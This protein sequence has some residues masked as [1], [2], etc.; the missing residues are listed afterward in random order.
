MIARV[1]SLFVAVILLVPLTVT[2]GANVASASGSSAPTVTTVIGLAQTCEST[3]ETCMPMSTAQSFIS[4]SP[5]TVV[6]TLD[7]VHCSNVA[8][9]LFVDGAASVTTPF[10]DPGKNTE[11]AVV[12]WP[13][14]G[15][16]HVLGYEGFGEVGG[17][18]EGNLITW[19]GSL[20]VTYVPVKSA[21]LSVSVKLARSTIAQGSQVEATATVGASGGSVS[22]ITLGDGLTSSDDTIASVAP[23]SPGGF[24]LDDGSSKKFTFTVNA[25]AVGSVQ[26]TLNASGT[27]SS[28][29]N[30]QASG[31]ATLNVKQ[32]GIVVNTT[33]DD[34]IDDK[35]LSPDSGAPFCAI[36]ASAAKP[37]CSLRAA[38]QLV[39]KLGGHQTITFDIPGSGVPKIAVPSFGNLPKITASATI[40]GTTQSGGW[41]ELSS[42]EPLNAH[43]IAFDGSDSGLVLDGQ[44][45]SVRG[46]V[47]NGF[48]WGLWVESS[49]DDVVGDRIGT[50][51]SGEVAA[52]NAIGVFI[53]GPGAII[54]GTSGTSATSCTGDCD[55]I[56]GNA[57]E[58][59]WVD[60]GGGDLVEG[61]TIGADLTGQHL[62]TYRGHTSTGIKI[63]AAHVTIGGPITAPGQAPGNVIGSSVAGLDF[64]GTNLDRAPADLQS[65]VVAGNLIGV[66]RSGKEGLVSGDAGTGEVSSSSVKGCPCGILYVPTSSATG[67]VIGGSAAN[68]E[69]VISGWQTGVYLDDSSTTSQDSTVIDHD[70]I[71]TDSSGTAAIPNGIG[72]AGHDTSTPE[73]DFFKITG[74][75][76]LDS[77]VSGNEYGLDQ[78]STVQGD[79]VGTIANGTAAL[80]NDVGVLY[81]LNI[82]GPRPVG[83]TSCAFPCNLISGNSGQG[84]VGAQTVQGNFIGTNLDGTAAVP[85]GSGFTTVDPTSDEFE[86][87]AVAFAA[88]IGGPSGALNGVCDQ[89]C[90]LISGNDASG[91]VSVTEATIP[92]PA[93][94]SV[95]IDIP[96]SV[97]LPPSEHELLI[98]G[99]LIGRSISNQALPNT[100]GGI[101][102]AY[103]KDSLETIGGDGVKGNVIADNSGPA[104][105]TTHARPSYFEVDGKLYRERTSLPIVEGNSIVGNTVGILYPDKGVK[106][107]GI[108]IISSATTSGGK[109][110]ISGEATKYSSGKANLV[111]IDVFGSTT[112]KSPQGETPLGWVYAGPLSADW[113]LKVQSSA[114]NYAFFTATATAPADGGTSKFSDCFAA[115]T[116]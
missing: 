102:T 95:T 71:G 50:D 98:E 112:C 32:L 65:E 2:T 17:C 55:L 63:T 23:M 91:I 30:V 94:W 39:N 114:Q 106:G 79:F 77:L 67:P 41:V 44:G 103:V 35:A 27:T 84:V 29:A 20:S 49:G 15:K 60:S 111:R 45:S 99:N 78:V 88:T 100:L 58:Q 43:P 89:A 62:L 69:N 18:N 22:S 40:D 51:P 14:D 38:I 34:K 81:S 57:T 68:D 75:S 1:R 80:P 72:V 54:G 104:V 85:N 87:G 48:S 61:D 21:A 52:P 13:N 53:S 82:G 70:L 83:S 109:L 4:S 101:I 6:F 96:L 92:R 12:P 73:H 3:G 36:D 93:G 42:T 28:G 31:Q 25:V 26:L 37:E 74:G 33:S 90:N 9:K 115:S 116:G 76:V 86:G 108:P 46:L 19:S 8:V 66:T 107:P 16:A 113:T 97:G 56:A 10:S 7:A 11:K 5:L 59:V 105:W 47:I 110:I 24:S 64:G